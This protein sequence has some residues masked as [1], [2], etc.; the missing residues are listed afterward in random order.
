[1]S[2]AEAEYL[3][4]KAAFL[5]AQRRL[6]A[7]KAAMRPILNAKTQAKA[8]AR[9]HVMAEAIAAYVDG[10]P[11]YKAVKMMRERGCPARCMCWTVSDFCREVGLAGIRLKYTD[12][13]KDQARYRRIGKIALKCYH[14]A[15]EAA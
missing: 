7:A 8:G 11:Q 4:A 10:M 6:Q 9:I 2:G 12:G 14:A 1:M 3:A 13:E 5:A 15:R